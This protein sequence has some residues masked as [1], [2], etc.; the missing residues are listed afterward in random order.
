MHIKQIRPRL[1]VWQSTRSG[2]FD[3]REVIRILY[4]ADGQKA[5]VV[6]LFTNMDMKYDAGADNL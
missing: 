2:N 3:T 6:A 4:W 1:F 5:N